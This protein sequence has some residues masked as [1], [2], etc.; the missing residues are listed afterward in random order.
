MSDVFKPMRSI[1]PETL[2]QVSWPKFG[3]PKLDGIRVAKFQGKSRTKSGK[4]VPNT[5]L[6]KWIE[7]YLPDGLDCEVTYGEATDPAVYTKTFSAVMA[8]DKPLDNL[9]LHVFDTCDDLT[10]YMVDR[11]SKVVRLV[12]EVIDTAVTVVAVPQTMLRSKEE[13]VAYYEA[14]LALG[15]EGVILRDPTGLYKYGKCTVRSQAQFKMKP[16]EDAEALVLSLF[17]GETNNNEAFT[18]EV[19]ETKRSSHQENKSYNGRL[20]GFV[21]I[22]PEDEAEY[23]ETGD[24]NLVFRISSGKMTHEEGRKLLQEWIS[25]GSKSLPSSY[26]KYRSM[27]Y[28]TMTNGRPRHGRFIGW[29]G[30]ADMEPT[31]DA[32]A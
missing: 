8:H 3:S 24:Q 17:E 15:Y 20:G 26:I 10:S 14:Q 1:A 25:S 12:G 19:G 30:V 29:R 13:F 22:R 2:D 28:G 6:R 16:E 4:P 7:A 18:N 32:D 21:C 9:T 23:T 27:S 5:Q 31:G 11:Y